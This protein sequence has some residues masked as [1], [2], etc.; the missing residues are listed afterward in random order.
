MTGV[1]G[2]GSNVY[3]AGNKT[4]TSGPEMIARCY[5]LPLSDATIS[6]AT[7][8]N[9]INSVNI[10]DI[11][12]DGDANGVGEIWAATDDS[13]SPVKCYAS[14]G[15]PS[16]AFP[17]SLISA[18]R[19]IAFY[20]EGALDYVWVSNPDDNKISL[21]S[22][23]PTGIEGG[24]HALGEIVL[25]SSMNPFCES[26]TITATG[27]SENATVEI[28]DVTGR[29]ILSSSFNGTFHWNG[30]GSDGAIVPGGYYCIRVLDTDGWT[31]TLSIVKL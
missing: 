11:A 19:G 21:V 22:V 4:S 18:A 12:Y 13:D 26:V 29:S 3:M 17:G 23:D 7:Y 14:T 9:Q 1:G 27:V 8:I 31:A 28:Y 20:S 24:S 6:F 10:F 5:P 30:H 25:S 2:N 16:M 15:Y